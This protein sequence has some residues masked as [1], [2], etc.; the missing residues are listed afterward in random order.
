MK[1]LLCLLLLASLS[2]LAQEKTP[3]HMPAD[4]IYVNG[5]IYLGYFLVVCVDECEPQ[6]TL[7]RKSVV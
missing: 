4:T 7:D 1:R 2:V 5:R 6:D 3:L